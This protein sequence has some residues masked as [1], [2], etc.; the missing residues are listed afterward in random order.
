MLLILGET[1]CF[2]IMHAFLHYDVLKLQ[3]I[4]FQ[5][6][7]VKLPQIFYISH[8]QNNED[9]RRQV[10]LRRHLCKETSPCTTSKSEGVLFS[11]GW[12]GP[13]RAWRNA[14]TEQQGQT[15]LHREAE[16]LVLQSHRTHAVTASN[17]SFRAAQGSRSS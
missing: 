2:P 1:F 6:D 17:C 13:P 12:R 16:N 7:F 14:Y 8:G 3:L 5:N 10:L 4:S 15:D 9:L 11:P